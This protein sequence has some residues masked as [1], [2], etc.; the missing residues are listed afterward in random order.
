MT[1]HMALLDY[2]IAANPAEPVSNGSGARML[3]TV[4]ARQRY[5]WIRTGSLHR[6]SLPGCANALVS[7]DESQAHSWAHLLVRPVDDISSSRPGRH[8]AAARSDGQ[9]WPDG[10]AT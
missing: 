10:E 5:S 9:G 3:A 1:W 6:R 8:I 2:C 4:L 7:G